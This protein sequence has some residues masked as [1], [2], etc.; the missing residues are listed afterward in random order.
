MATCGCRGF[1][2]GYMWLQVVGVLLLMVM[3]T[4]G[5]KLIEAQLSYQQEA[6]RLPLSAEEIMEN[7]RT[8]TCSH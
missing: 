1:A 5:I 7:W 3:V 8:I 6:L 2:D 4:Q